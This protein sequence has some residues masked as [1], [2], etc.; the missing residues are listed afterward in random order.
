M[1]KTI[2]VIGLGSIGARHAGILTGFGHRVIGH[3]VAIIAKT[4]V[5]LVQ[6][7]KLIADSEAIVVASPTPYHAE[8]MNRALTAVKH[9][10]VEKPISHDG[11]DTLRTLLDSAHLSSRRCVVMVGYMLRF[12]SCVIAARDWITAGD[13]GTPLWGNFTCAQFNEKPAYLR[14]GVIFNWSHE[15]DLA[16]YLLGPGH[17]AAASA[18]IKD[19]SD[20]LADIIIE[21]EGGARSAVHLDYLTRPEIRQ[22]LVVGTAGTII[23]DLAHRQAWLRDADGG[24]L[25][26]H[27]GTDSWD[28]NYV[29]EMRAFI[30]R[31][32]GKETLG[33]TG[34][35]GLA[36]LQVCLDARKIAG[37]S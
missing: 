7:D 29:D 14:D 33:A 32:D 36:A 13:I 25:E 22:S 6:L 12:H 30:D 28:Q 21:H 34:E 15:I 26:H 19:G 11:I 5:P 9:V 35:E 8:H 10:F 20:D 24:V 18:R 17:V 1:S 3:D 16:L 23:M 27:I 4:S 2:G 31:I 37:V